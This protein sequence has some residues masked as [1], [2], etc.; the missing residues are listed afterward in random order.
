MIIAEY[1]L[2]QQ[3]PMIHFQY[4]E[5]RATLRASEVKPKLDRFILAQLGGVEFVRKHHPEWFVS[6]DQPALNFKLRFKPKG[7]PTIDDPPKELFFANMGK[8]EDADDYRRTILYPDGIK[9]VAVCFHKDLQTELD[10]LLPYFFALHAF[11]TRNGKGF[12]CFSVE[13]SQLV[14]EV[15]ETYCPL[16]VYY[17][18]KFPEDTPAKDIL[19]DIWVISGMMK[20]GFNFTFRQPTDY[21]KGHIFRYFTEKEIGGDKAFIKQ[22]VLVGND[23]DQRSE[24]Y[25]SYSE[26]RFVRAMLG[27]PGGFEFKS[28]PKTTRKGK[29]DVSSDIKRFQSPVVYRIQNNQLFI[30]PQIIPKRM[31]NA[32]FQLNDQPIATPNDFDLIDFLDSFAA[33]FNAHT[34]IASFR[35]TEISNSLIIRKKLVINRRPEK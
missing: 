4:D 24:E 32:D 27:L 11:G 26:F 16:K 25:S 12:G 7:Q 28:G 14:S 13:K 5:E 22:K 29:V 34:D 31:M 15:M 23:T 30:I 33:R 9:M 20:S 8:K 18:I 21:Y 19:H 3:T 2:I 17:T 35:S 6:K 1:H 10:R